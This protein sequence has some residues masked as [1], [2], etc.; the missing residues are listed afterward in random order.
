MGEAH[1]WT[2]T[3]ITGGPGWGCFTGDS[4]PPSLSTV[5]P[6]PCQLCLPQPVGCVSTG[7]L[8]TT[9]RHSRAPGHS[10]RTECVCGA[11]QWPASAGLAGVCSSTSIRFLFKSTLAY[12]LLLLP[13][14][15]KYALVWTWRIIFA[16]TQTS[17][18]AIWNPGLWGCCMRT[19]LPSPPFSESCCQRFYSLIMTKTNIPRCHS[20]AQLLNKKR[21]R[22]GKKATNQISNSS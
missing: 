20:K 15:I 6:F 13:K 19:G 3:F 18:Y 7:A 10:P 1:W 22:K 9:N 5:K 14:K 8:L 17:S 21:K 4:S 12:F 16:F 11:Q 2:H